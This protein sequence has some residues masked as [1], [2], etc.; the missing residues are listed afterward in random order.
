[1]T[2]PLPFDPDTLRAELEAALASGDLALDQADLEA[3]ALGD[4]A[5]LTPDDFALDSQINTRIHA[6]QKSRMLH[7]RLVRY[8]NAQ[9][10][11][12]DLGPLSDPG[13][14]THVWLGGNFI[15]GD[16]IEAWIVANDWL[17][18]DLHIATLSL[19]GDN[20]DSL[21]NLFHGDYVQRL[22]LMV[23]DYWFSH[24]RHRAGLVPYVYQE[25]DQGGDRFQLTVTGSHAK[26]ALIATDQGAC[27]VLH[28]SANLRSSISMEQIAIEHDPDL[29]G[30]YL[31]IHQA[32]EAQYHT[33]YPQQPGPA[34]PKRSQWQQIAQ[35]SAA[36]TTPAVAPPGSARPPAPR[37]SAAPRS[38]DGAGAVPSDRETIHE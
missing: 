14:R 28:G 29:Y 20:I 38:N 26:V 23:S 7:P 37:S 10:L 1:M 34:A 15:Y 30:F 13:D 33:I 35:V 12:R 11:A 4:P 22:H 6:P 19:S 5:L 8:D 9:A 2:A 27:Y 24:E 18:P 31:D 36:A 16:F 25:L 32:L 21:A 17:I 3:F